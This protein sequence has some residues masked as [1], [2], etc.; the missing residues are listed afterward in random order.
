MKADALE[1]PKVTAAASNPIAA[2]VCK[3][4]FIGNFPH[5]VPTRETLLNI[6]LYASL[7][8]SG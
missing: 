5:P 7:M 8:G 2:N 4:Y 6:A 1:A 3:A